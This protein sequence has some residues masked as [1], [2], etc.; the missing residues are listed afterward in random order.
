[1]QSFQL[2]EAF[3]CL[4]EQFFSWPKTFIYGQ[5]KLYSK[6]F[7]V[8]DKKVTG[9]NFIHLVSHGINFPDLFRLFS[10]QQ[11]LVA[12][13]SFLKSYNT[14][15]FPLKWGPWGHF[16]WDTQ[17]WKNLGVLRKSNLVASL[18][19]FFGINSFYSM[20][21]DKLWHFFSILGAPYFFYKK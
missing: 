10:L 1:M 8:E 12:G 15:T 6:I 21:L 16:S 5:L 13:R 3:Q 11:L 17:F 7:E 9:F 14:C 20:Y 2:L 18:W 19:R 4:V